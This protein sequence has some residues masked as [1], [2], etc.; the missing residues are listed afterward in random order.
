MV[1]CPYD[2]CPTH[3]NT[4][5]VDGN[6]SKNILISTFNFIV[7]PMWTVGKVHDH[8]L[9]NIVKYFQELV[10][11]SLANPQIVCKNPTCKRYMDLKDYM[12]MELYAQA[13]YDKL[14]WDKPSCFMCKCSLCVW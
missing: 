7:C 3:E 13:K 2:L 10:G 14:I 11:S 12:Y 8:F 9:F 6:L 4:L 1:G 5:M